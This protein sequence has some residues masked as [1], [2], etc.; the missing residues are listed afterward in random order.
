MTMELMWPRRLAW[1]GCINA[2]DLGGLPAGEGRQTRWGAVVRSEDPVALSEAGVAALVDHGVRTIVDLRRP[3]ELAQRPSP[4][5][6]P[7]AHGVGYANVPFEHDTVGAP[8]ANDLIGLYRHLLDRH[9]MGIAAVMSAITR[10]PEGGVL[11]H[12]H[13]GMD[14]T[15]LVSAFLLDLAGVARDL[16]ADDYAFTAECTREAAA[17]WLENGPGERAERERIARVF[18]PRAEVMQ[19]SLAYLDE[20]HGGPEAYLRQAGVTSDQ[21]ERLRDRLLS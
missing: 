20:R 18:T 11:V 5:A 2:R 6:E 19:A 16:I 14:R 4:F 12:C 7:A 13:A 8:T 15:G 21:V 10:A 3:D 17:D 1:E 9:A